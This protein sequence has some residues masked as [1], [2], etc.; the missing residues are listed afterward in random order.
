MS[1][2]NEDSVRHIAKLA[3]LSLTDDEVKKFTHDLSEVVKYVEQLKELDT[4][5]VEPMVGAVEI[6]KE[7]RQDIAIDSGLRDEMLKNA[8]DAEDT[9]IKVP[10]MS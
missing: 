2:I 5:G 4:E 8:P 6:L 10:Q 9:A 7:L 1:E 3:R